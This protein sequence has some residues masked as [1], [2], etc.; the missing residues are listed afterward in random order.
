MNLRDAVDEYLTLK[1][2]S[3]RLQDE[4][5]E[6]EKSRLR[7]GAAI[8][9]AVRELAPKGAKAIEFQVVGQHFSIN[10]AGELLRINQVAVADEDQPIELSE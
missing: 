10:G 8:F 7:F 4:L 1:E 6:K 2:Q 3:K 5:E 9:Q